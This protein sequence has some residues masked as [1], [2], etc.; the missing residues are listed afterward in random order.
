VLAMGRDHPIECEHGVV[1]DWGDFQPSGPTPKCAICAA[2][3]RLPLPGDR[4]LLT[5]DEVIAAFP[6]W[7]FG[8][9]ATYEAC[10]RGEL[11]S[12]RIGRR[13]FLVN[14]ELRRLLGLEVR[15][16]LDDGGGESR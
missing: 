15:D 1:L 12:V 16:D 5:V 4:P 14:A 13:L 10:R 8:R 9:T 2:S 3:R 6:G 7:P 11:P